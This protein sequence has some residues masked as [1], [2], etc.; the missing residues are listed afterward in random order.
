MDDTLKLVIP[1]FRGVHNIDPEASAQRLKKANSYKDLSTVCIIHT[2]GLINAKIA[3]N[4]MNQISQMNQKFIRL[5]IVGMEKYEAFNQTIEFAL[6]S[7]GMRDFKYI[8]TMEEDTL[9]PFDGLVKLFE[10]IEKYDVVGG[11]KFSQGI[12]G[13]PMVY[14]H[15]QMI[16]ASYVS[17]PLIPEA[18]QECLGIGTAFTLFKLDIFKNPDLKKPWFKKPNLGGPDLAFFDNIHKLGYK[19]ACDTRVRLGNFDSENQ[20]VW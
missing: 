19:V 6:A 7:P 5:P 13:K 2:S 1:D 4:W 10:S 12:E 15:P 16:P 18:I 9:V 14:G 11:L 8:L 20:L 3:E 17:V